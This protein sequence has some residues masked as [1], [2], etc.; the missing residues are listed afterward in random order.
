MHFSSR[1]RL[2][3]TDFTRA[4]DFAQA[5]LTRMLAA[6]Y[7]R[8]T[9]RERTGARGYSL[10]WGNTAGATGNPG[11]PA[12]GLVV[13][14]LL[15][16]PQAG[17]V[18]CHVQ[19]GALALWVPTTNPD[20][21]GLRL[22]H[23]PGE[24]TGALV[25]TPN[26]SGSTRI[27]VVE[28][29]YVERVAEVDNRDVFDATT[30]AFTPVAVTKVS[31]GQLVYRVRAGVA[32]AGYPGAEAG[33]LPLA[34]CSVPAGTTTWDQATL[35]DVRP[36]AA[37]LADATPLVSELPT[38]RRQ[39]F[40]WEVGGVDGNSI[41]QRGYAEVEY[42]GRLVGGVCQ[43]AR[44]WDSVSAT[45]VV[46]NPWIDL[47]DVVVGSTDREPTISLANV[48]PWYVWLVFPFGLPRWCRYQ[49]IG[50]SPLRT[51]GDLCGIP[52]VS[53]TGPAD[54]RGSPPV[55]P[56]APPVK[57]GL[58]SAATTVAVMYLSGLTNSSG[59]P[60]GSRVD[61]HATWVAGD[62]QTVSP[63]ST[64]ANE[65]ADW[66]LVD[67]VRYPA[68]ARALH[69]QFSVS[70]TTGAVFDANLL[71]RVVTWQS[72]SGGT[73]NQD[74]TVYGTAVFVP[75]SKTHLLRLTVRLPMHPSY[76]WALG[77][78]TRRFRLLY[79]ANAVGATGATPLVRVTGWEIGP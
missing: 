61:G 60:L 12:R 31:D 22:V 59:N 23:D 44:V 45:N 77:L 42:A 72:L 10:P 75:I 69:L 29:A 1:E 76:P 43:S 36:L 47:Q 38:Y 65:S 78:N 25:L 19:A 37:D 58:G 2:V 26:A 53:S 7:D 17:T 34:V 63:T 48:A 73:S 52:V 49:E 71:A 39:N 70:V 6:F 62:G 50:D 41:A 16:T 64:V 68:N 21:Y 74:T 51:P 18:V 24:N 28:C 4:T 30:G 56:V 32:G 79:E 27:D 11:V 33:W 66:G 9:P 40:G 20:E 15:A 54:Y 55:A 35:W 13:G 3:S 8:L 57:Y 14:G 67:N 5:D 46:T